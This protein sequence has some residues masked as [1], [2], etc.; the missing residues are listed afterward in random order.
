LALASAVNLAWFCSEEG[1]SPLPRGLACKVKGGVKGVPRHEDLDQADS[2]GDVELGVLQEGVEFPGG[3]HFVRRVRE[4]LQS[5][6]ERLTV[7]GGGTHGLAA[8]HERQQLL[9]VVHL[10]VVVRC[11]DAVDLAFDFVAGERSVR[12]KQGSEGERGVSEV[13]IVRGGKTHPSLLITNK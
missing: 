6:L 9:V 11:L 2:I 4:F 8:D 10:D 5:G 3:V 7:W 13:R 12:A 1:A